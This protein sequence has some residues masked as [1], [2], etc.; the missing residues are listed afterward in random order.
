MTGRDEYHNKI[1]SK[2]ESKFQ[3]YPEYISGFYYY[4][5]ASGKIKSPVT[6]NIYINQ[7]LEFY[8]YC[9]KDLTKV[10]FDDITKYFDKCSYKENG[11]KKCGNVVAG[12][13]AALRKFYK[14][15]V[16]AKR[17]D[18]N[19]LDYMDAPAQ[20]IPEEVDRTY[21][22][23]KEVNIFVKHLYKKIESKNT[24]WRNSWGKRDLSV[25]ML[26]LTCGMRNEAIMNMNVEDIDFASKTLRTIEKRNNY[27]EYKLNDYLLDILSDWINA[28][29][30]LLSGY[31]DI[32]ALFIGKKR[33]RLS[34]KAVNELIGRYTECIPG[35][36][37]TAHKLRATYG[38]MIYNKTHDLYFTQTCLGHSNPSTTEI[39][40]RDQKNDTRNPSEMMLSSINFKGF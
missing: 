34:E 30:G 24:E 28:R 33:T 9:D 27:R 1:E 19:P 26:L 3:D 36:H 16:A 8:R 11:E 14:Y 7:V 4:M 21:L 38:S 22:D 29:T 20:T 13:Y 25:I 12:K 2:I 10:T 35:K 37:I 6:Y 15:M 23:A 5:K 40:I 32:D 31:P 39:Y 18:S 17:I